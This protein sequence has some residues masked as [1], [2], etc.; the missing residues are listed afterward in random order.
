MNDVAAK[1]DPLLRVTGLTKSYR[2]GGRDLPVLRGIDLDVHRGEWLTVLGASGSGKSTLLHLM[3]GLDRPDEGT[4]T[5][6]GQSVSGFD[7][8]Q[9]N[10]YRNRQVGFVFQ[11]YHLLPELTA[12][13]NVFIAGCITGATS[14]ARL[15]QRAAELLDQVGL[16]DRTTH[17]PHKLSGG[18]R[19]RVAIARSLMNE[20]ELLLA[21]EPTGN[22]DRETGQS[23]MQTLRRLHPPGKTLILVTHDAKIAEQGDRQIMLTDGRV[24]TA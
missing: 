11:F 9:L 20:P 3:G 16:A 17:R 4:L 13:E 15:R 1:P 8:K 18:E 19:Q 2:M 14:K 12:L 24:V 6:D 10:H 7:R 22:L 23:V 5:F 21:D